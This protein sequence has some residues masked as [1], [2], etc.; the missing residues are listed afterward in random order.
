MIEFFCLQTVHRCMC[1]MG[2]GTRFIHM[3][4]VP[5]WVDAVLTSAGCI[6]K[7]RPW[8]EGHANPW[9]RDTAK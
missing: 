3:S 9:Q 8:A 4:W 2:G 5:M 6:D 1:A 7:R